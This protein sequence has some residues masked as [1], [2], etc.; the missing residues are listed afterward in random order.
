MSL[1]IEITYAPLAPKRRGTTQAIMSALRTMKASPKDAEGNPASFLIAKKHRGAVRV[2]STET[3][4][5]V[6]TRVEGD[7]VRVFLAH[8]DPADKTAPLPGI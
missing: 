3:N 4:I 1:K 6:R 8:A 2:A 5:K 7:H